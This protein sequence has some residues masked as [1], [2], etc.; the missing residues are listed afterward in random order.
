MIMS[1]AAVP[2]A[3]A[4]P[5]GEA[6]AQE[7]TIPQVTSPLTLLVSLNKQRMWVYDANGLVTSS[8]VSTGMAGFDTPKGV[9][10]II[11]KKVDHSSNIYEGASMPYMQRLLQTGIAMHGG[12][13]PATRRRTAA[14]VCRSRLRPSS[15]T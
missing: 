14:S 6:A 4:K 11:E 8:R 9:Y 12:V 10:A 15:S 5:K 13:V 3:M 2:A 7:E 1:A